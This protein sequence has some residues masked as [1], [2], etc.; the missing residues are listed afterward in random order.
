MNVVFITNI[1]SSHQEGWTDLFSTF[2]DVN[3]LYL[4][5]RLN[6]NFEEERR[7]VCTNKLYSKLSIN[8]DLHTLNNIL[9][10]AD[11][12]LVGSVEDKRIYS[13][14]KNK[15]N[16]IFMFEHISKFNYHDLYKFRGIRSKFR[17]WK[18]RNN[19]LKYLNLKPNYLLSLS[20]YSPKDFVMSGM[21]KNNCYNFGYFPKYS[22]INDKEL[23]EKDNNLSMF[24]G[25]VEWKHPE[26]ALK[27]HQLLHKNNRNQKLEI[28]GFDNAVNTHDIQYY[29]FVEHSKIIRQ[30]KKASIFI[31]SSDRREGWGVALAEAMSC[32][33]IVFANK[34]AGATNILVNKENG[35][36]FN[37]NNSLKRAI[38]KYQK[39][40]DNEK[41]QMRINAVNTIKNLYSPENAAIRLR[42]F[43]FTLKNKTK[44][45]PYENGPLSRAKIK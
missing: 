16:L 22:Y 21:K 9:N 13:N 27:I 2:S 39:M 29:G 19:R 26:T 30:L 43:L 8:M 31:F 42:E 6:P 34:D 11:F 38:K 7:Y 3:F 37:S 28:Y 4:C 35:F 1:L 17:F 41:M 45:I 36:S 33:C 14:I 24:I 20:Y 44:F 32:G 18:T 12:I 15:N 5:T 40:T 25:R 23:K 10:D